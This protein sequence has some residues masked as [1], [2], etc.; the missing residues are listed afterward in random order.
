MKRIHQA[1]AIFFI[2][3][4]A[5]I[6]WESWKFEYYT[7]LGPGPGFFPFW[8]AVAM[9]VLSLIWLLQLFGKSW[10]PEPKAF[11]PPWQGIFRILLILVAMV[12]A[13]CFMDFLGFQLTMFL[14]LVFLL[15]VLGRQ[16]LW[17]AL[18]LSLF[19]SVGVFH[20]F[21]RYLDVPLPTAA[22]TFLSNLSL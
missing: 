16:M 4:S 19:C 10:T 15:L 6:A 3:L 11:F 5:S 14:F 13:A 20:L 9:G 12:A 21:S 22:I 7:N 18:V 17:V 1:A 8:L 2:A